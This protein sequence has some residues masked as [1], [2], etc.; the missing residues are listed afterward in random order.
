MHQR[1]MMSLHQYQ[2]KIAESVGYLRYFTDYKRP[3]ICFLISRLVATSRNPAIRHYTFLQKVT[4]YL[5]GTN[6]LGIVFGPHTGDKEYCSESI[7]H[8]ANMKASDRIGYKS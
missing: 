2:Q 1:S 7:L 6:H 8:G 4:R 3:G 5:M